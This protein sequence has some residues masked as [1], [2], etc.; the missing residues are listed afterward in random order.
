MAER[1]TPTS[2]ETQ[3]LDAAVRVIATDGVRGLRIEKLAAQAGV[4]PALIYHY[5]SDRSGILRA[6]LDAINANAQRYTDDEVRTAEPSA[7]ICELL[8]LEMQRKDAVRQNSIA[9]GELRASAVFNEELRQPLKATTAAWNAQVAQLIRR[10]Q[11]DLT[12][13]A[14]VQADDAAERLTSLV[15]GLSER[16]HSGSLT[17][18]R[19]RALLSGAISLELGIPE[20]IGSKQTKV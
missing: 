11:T 14:H 1:S 7:Q 2:R 18:A 15:E 16:W 13:A 8:L 20:P 12:V 4:S 17:L 3:I 10:A 6:A 19:A 5:F 9:W